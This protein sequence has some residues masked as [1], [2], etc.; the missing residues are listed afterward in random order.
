[1]E[2]VFSPI[3]VHVCVHVCAYSKHCC[4]PFEPGSVWARMSAASLGG[5][6]RLS[7]E[8]G[9]CLFLLGVEM[10]YVSVV[11][12]SAPTSPRDHSLPAPPTSLPFLQNKHP[13]AQT[14]HPA[15]AQMEPELEL[16]S[17]VAK[18]TGIQSSL[19]GL[20]LPPRPRPC[21]SWPHPSRPWPHPSRPW[22]HPLPQPQLVVPLCPWRIEEGED[23]CIKELGS[24]PYSVALGLVGAWTRS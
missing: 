18:V 17:S 9:T 14:T 24:R 2:P 5:G 10:L 6:L 20:P 1:M 19:S 21:L 22:P 4:L 16:I 12:V 15:K 11:G 23:R 13:R 8:A 7:L 3:C